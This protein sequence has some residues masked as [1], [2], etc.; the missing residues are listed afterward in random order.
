VPSR[1]GP[2]PSEGKGHK[3]ESC[4]ARHDFNDLAGL[5]KE[6]LIAAEAPWKHSTGSNRTVCRTPV[7]NELALD[8]LQKG[9]CSADRWPVR[10]CAE[11]TAACAHGDRDL[12]LERK[13]MAR[14]RTH[15]RSTQNRRFSPCEERLRASIGSN[16]GS[17]TNDSCD[18]L[19]AHFPDWRHSWIDRLGCRIGL[20]IAKSVL[21]LMDTIQKIREPL[22]VVGVVYI[23]DRCVTALFRK[24]HCLGTSIEVS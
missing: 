21:R 15:L 4:R 7:G 3:F 1:A 20:D 6:P 12:Y 16:Q 11:H 9:A 8:E 13:S 19:N 5:A 10:L 22:L 14:M 17:P 24:P 2:L 23:P 18:W